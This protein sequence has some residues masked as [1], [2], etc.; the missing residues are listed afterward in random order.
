AGVRDRFER[1]EEMAL[2]VLNAGGD[3]LLDLED[4]RKEIHYLCECVDS[5]RLSEVS[6]EEVFGRLWALKRRMFGEGN[7]DS[8][9]D[10]TIPSGA[11]TALAKQIAA[12][13]ITIVGD[14]VRSPLPFS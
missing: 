3:L 5:H 14:S 11:A 9:T 1:E 2:A 8:T 4:P 7:T 13:A 6:V 10:H 12:G